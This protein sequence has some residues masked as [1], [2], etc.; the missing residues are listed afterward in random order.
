MSDII[1]KLGNKENVFMLGIWRVYVFTSFL[2]KK[3]S[4]QN[5]CFWF[6]QTNNS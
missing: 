1:R 6:V 2:E 5:I 4:K 3:N